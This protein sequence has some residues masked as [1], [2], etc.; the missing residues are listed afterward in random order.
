M[1]FAPR[2][3]VISAT[4]FQ[5]HLRNEFVYFLDFLS[6]QSTSPSALVLARASNDTST[7]KLTIDPIAIVPQNAVF[8]DTPC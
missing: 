2:V 1:V 3:A 4:F 7:T 6:L 8:F 5:H